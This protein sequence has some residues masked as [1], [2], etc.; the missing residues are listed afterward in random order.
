MQIRNKLEGQA[1][2]GHRDRT[3]F[4]SYLMLFYNNVA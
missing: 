3:K 1:P 4:D 2:S